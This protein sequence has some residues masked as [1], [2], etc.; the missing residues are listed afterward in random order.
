LKI[1]MTLHHVTCNILLL[2]FPVFPLLLPFVLCV[3]N[4]LA[5][6]ATGNE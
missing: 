3:S 5:K 1:K 6:T 4:G 2:L